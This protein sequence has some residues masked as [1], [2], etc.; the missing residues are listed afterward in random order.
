MEVRGPLIRLRGFVILKW[1]T[2]KAL[3]A[4]IADDTLKYIFFFRENKA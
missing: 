1:S 2:L 3:I 4:T